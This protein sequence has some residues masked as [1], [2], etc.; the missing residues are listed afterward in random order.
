M[1][2]AIDLSRAGLA[3][4][5]P[6]GLN[7]CVRLAQAM[8]GAGTQHRFFLILSDEDPASVTA[9][10]SM[11]AGTLPA[12]G[13]R[14]WHW[15]ARTA[16]DGRGDQQHDVWAS[17]AAA[18]FKQGLLA[19]LAVGLVLMPVAG[20]L[21]VTADAPADDQPKVGAPTTWTVALAADDDIEALATQQLRRCEAWWAA[22]SLPPTRQLG[23]RMKLAFVSPLPPQRSGIADYSAQLLPA[24]AQFY[25]VD[26][27]IDQAQL[28]APWVSA[29]CGVRD[30]QWLLDHAQ[31]YDRVMYHFGN[32][33]YHKHMFELLAR[34]PGVVVL[35]DFFLGDIHNY[36][37]VHGVVP[38]GLFR[39]LYES[40]GY[41]ALGV[42]AAEKDGA[43]VITQ[44]P[45][46]LG[47]VQ[48]S[49][50]VI[51]HS[52]HARQLAQTWYGREL[53]RRWQ[54]V[55]LPRALP[56]Q[57]NRQQARQQLALAPDDFV[58]CSFGLMGATK[59]NER[60]LEAWLLSPL[61]QDPRC[62]LVFVGE[63]HAGDYGAAIEAKISS[64]GLG[65]R[66]SITGWA[67]AEVFHSYLA[68]AD[69]AVQLRANSR[70]ETSAAVL[71]CM[72]HGLPTLV[73]A[74][75]AFAELPA[76]SVWLLPE[77][78]DDQA[79]ADAM[80]TL[81]LAPE[82]RRALGERAREVLG[83]AHSPETCAKQY[84]AAIEQA[85]TSAGA[86]GGRLVQALARLEGPAPSDSECLSL[87]R[88]IVQT[89]SCA[90]AHRQLLVDISATARHDLQTGIQ[91]VVRAL[92]KELINQPPEGFRV[93]PVYLTEQG[94]A[95]HYRYA[96]AWT[97]RAMGLSPELLPD[98][99]VDRWAG[100]MVLVAD[101]TSAYAVKAEQA[102]VFSALKQDGIGVYF[103]V[104][105]LLPIQRPEFFPPDQ[106]GF[107]D[108]IKTVAR[109]ADGA[110]C[111]SRAVAADLTAW[112]SSADVNRARPLRIDWFHLGADIE[113]SVPSKGLPE[114]A[115]SVLGRIKA[116]PS[117]LMVGTIEP[118]KGHLQTIEAFTR[119][120]QAGQDVN[121]VVVG[122]EGWRGV[123]DNARRSIPQTMTCLRSHAELG[124]RLLWLEDASDEYLEHAY[125]ASTC[126]IA[127]SEG[128]GFGLPLIEAAQR[129]MPILARDIPIFREVAGGHAY[130]F[131]GLAPEDLAD[132][133]M[134]WLRL[135]E[136]GQAPTSAQMPWL[137]WR[138]STDLLL[139]R[140]ELN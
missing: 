49:L 120:W 5:Q 74:H 79:L 139:T 125:A 47:V 82:Q 46:N 66:I 84:V 119:L 77:V 20:P 135:S 97:A 34:V 87:A 103:C 108:W 67:D 16:G 93:E 124:K 69:L 105:D 43:A 121:L 70:G 95:W 45:A 60:L 122:R 86:S 52:E 9:L 8:V 15:P 127:A 12:W 62:R 134:D 17:S 88:A 35:H 92:V 42:W 32:S 138:Q 118:R 50:G 65:D 41:A 56:Q 30:V 51:V 99:P 106:F 136:S 110:I 39:A 72:N 133:V 94:G 44:Y 98:E 27:I 57:G 73:N 89:R 59:L 71:D 23:S 128:E 36:L 114:N 13:V 63:A 131:E 53:A 101:F 58:V 116:R 123:P 111:I 85:Y 76:D 26:V 104:Y 107:L 3:G 6:S 25:D 31:G 102:G 19:D 38:H 140:L 115:E 137:T 68:G 96:R 40:H 91:R 33:S 18:L 129:K 64:S 1:R 130:F 10:R 24:L 22:N 113:N 80:T 55:A 78:F 14:S 83:S 7:P 11:M 90:R 81:W 48:Q 132:A 117:F 75:G 126:L 29:H 37:A 112:V 4:V 109:V 54:V 61:A 28:A 100:D 2:I 21:A